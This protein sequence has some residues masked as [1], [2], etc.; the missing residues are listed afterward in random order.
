MQQT[1][2]PDVATLLLTKRY[3]TIINNYYG[4]PNRPVEIHLT[5]DDIMLVGVL[6]EETLKKWQNQFR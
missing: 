5:K 1:L 4:Q 3:A 2:Q 6:G